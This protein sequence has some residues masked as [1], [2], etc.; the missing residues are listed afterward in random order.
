MIYANKAA[1]KALGKSFKGEGNTISP[2]FLMNEFFDYAELQGSQYLN[3]L[4]DFKKNYSV[5]NSVYTMKNGEYISTDKV[6]DDEE[7]KQFRNVEYYVKNKKMN[8]KE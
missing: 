2:M 7:I 4:S 5:I 1:K 6:S 8:V 3:Y